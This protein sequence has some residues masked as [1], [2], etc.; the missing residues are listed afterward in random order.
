GDKKCSYSLQNISKLHL[1]GKLKLQELWA[2]LRETDKDLESLRANGQGERKSFDRIYAYDVYNDIGAPDENLSL[3]HPVLGGDDYPYL[4]RCHT[5][6]ELSP[7]GTII[8][9]RTTQ[10]LA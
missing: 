10:N 8:H 5:G 2:R 6:G 1:E 4:R 9:I 3:A 7:T